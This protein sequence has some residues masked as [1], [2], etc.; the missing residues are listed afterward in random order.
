MRQ[1][2]A[3]LVDCGALGL[4]ATVPPASADCRL[5]RRWRRRRG[6]RRE[7]ARACNST[8]SRCCRRRAHP[9][10]FSLLCASAK[11]Q[12]N[13]ICVRARAPIV[14]GK[15]APHTQ[16]LKLCSHLHAHAGAPTDFQRLRV[17]SRDGALVAPPR[18]R[19]RANSCER[20][21]TRARRRCHFRRRSHASLRLK[22]E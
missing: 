2:G 14:G 15:R 12:V 11:I 6:S 7:R 4:S 19:A 22:A 5:R 1:G 3:P 21:R 8:S 13:G 10:S 18:T 17:P 9:R 16:T 20:D